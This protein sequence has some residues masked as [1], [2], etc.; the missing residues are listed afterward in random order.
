MLR[1]LTSIKREI[2]SFTAPMRG[3]ISLTFAYM[4]IQVQGV[5]TCRRL[6]YLSN[7]IA[8]TIDGGVSIEIDDR[9]EVEFEIGNEKM[10]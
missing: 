4:L 1:S 10:A 2:N 7:R 6:K 8:T 5:D 9:K 3:Q